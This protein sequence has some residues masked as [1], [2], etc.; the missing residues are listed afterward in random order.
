MAKV[1]RQ[2]DGC[3][4]NWQFPLWS[5]ICED[6]I[7]AGPYFYISLQSCALDNTLRSCKMSKL[8]RYSYYG[9]LLSYEVS[10]YTCDLRANGM[11]RKP[12]LQLGMIKRIV[13]GLSMTISITSRI[14]LCKAG[15]IQLL[16]RKP[17]NLANFTSGVSRSAN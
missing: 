3:F 17:T 15:Y 12:L 16:Y 4:A 8:G 6:H 13:F 1:L 7:V 10:I 9:H 5:D 11:E 2:W 14:W